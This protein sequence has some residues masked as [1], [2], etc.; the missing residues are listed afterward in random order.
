MTDQTYMK[1]YFEWLELFEELTAEEI[2]TLVLASMKYAKNKEI[3][4]FEGRELRLA[5]KAIKGTIDRT[6]SAHESR[7]EINRANGQKGGAPK[8]NT[9]ASKTTETTE[10]NQKQPK[11]TENKH[12]NTYTYTNT[13]TDTKTETKTDPNTN[14]L[15]LRAGARESESVPVAESIFIPPSVADVEVYCQHKGY[16]IDAE[17]FVDFYE[18]KG[19]MV[20]SNPMRSWHAAVRNWARNHKNDPPEKGK[21]SIMDEMKDW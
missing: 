6:L 2:G 4:D 21:Q 17:A 18:S 14:T 3:P 7:A 11:T 12:T 5:W 10:N 15:S 9:N 16:K 1:F 13:N 19:W 20:G 8:G